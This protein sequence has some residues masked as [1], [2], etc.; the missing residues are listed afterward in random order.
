[1]SQNI[2]KCPRFRTIWKKTTNPI[3]KFDFIYIEEQQ[4]RKWE[5]GDS[6]ENRHAAGQDR[7]GNSDEKN[8]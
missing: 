5:N 6:K 1:M 8:L 3:C 2:N 4:R 7:F